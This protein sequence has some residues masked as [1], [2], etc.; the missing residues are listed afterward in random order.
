MYTRLITEQDLTYKADTEAEALFL[1]PT[2]NSN[3]CHM[4]LNC[5]A[6]ERHRLGK[7]DCAKLSATGM[8]VCL[9]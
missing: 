3:M 9:R 4:Y 5:V 2:R 7:T 1:S 6:A 8:P